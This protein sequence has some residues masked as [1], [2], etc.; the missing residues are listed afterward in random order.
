MW[1]IATMSLAR[2]IPASRQ[3]SQIRRDCSE[4][5]VKQDLGNQLIEFVGGFLDGV[6]VILGQRIVSVI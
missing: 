4:A 2:H 3:Q 1:D 6:L 5:G